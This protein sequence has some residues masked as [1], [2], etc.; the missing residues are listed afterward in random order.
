MLLNKLK[1]KKAFTLAEVLI[2]LAIIGIVAAMTIPSVVNST[3]NSEIVA[4]VKKYQSVFSQVYLKATNDN[5]C[6]GDLSSCGAFS[7]TGQDPTAPWAF[8]KPYLNVIKDCGT[9]TGCYNPGV[10]YKSLNY[11]V[12]GTSTINDNVNIFSK[13]VLADGAFIF[14]YKES[15]ANCSTNGSVSTNTT[16]PLYNSVCGSFYVDVNGAK[17]PNQEGRDEF[18]YVIA[19]TGIYPAGMDGTI[20][21]GCNPS[22]GDV[23]ADD[24]GAPG[25]GYCTA[26]ILKEGAINY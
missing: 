9:S 21:A 1:N 13:A 12:S 2:T 19:K 18:S 7:V 24:S 26:R 15:A 14:L 20:Y 10:S 3:N 5:G 11:A 6:L 22:S 8:F 17:G 25:V 16:G 4:K 23:T